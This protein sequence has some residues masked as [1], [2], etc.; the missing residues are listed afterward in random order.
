MIFKDLINKYSWKD[1]ES[2]F[3]NLYPEDKLE[4]YE[5]AYNEIKDIE[6][7]E[8]DMTIHVKKVFDEYDNSEYFS[9]DGSN[10]TCYRDS[11]DSKFIEDEEVLNTEIGYALEFTEWNK[12]MGMRI[13]EEDLQTVGEKDFLCYCLWEMTFNGF[14]EKGTTEY[15]EDFHEKCE[16]WE[17]EG[18]K[19]K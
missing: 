8:Y 3:H 17:E 9:V 19:I 12:W 14:T 5:Y 15:I 18:K 1:L 2:I 7:V 6:P 11:S 10:G 16:G 4:N 13:S